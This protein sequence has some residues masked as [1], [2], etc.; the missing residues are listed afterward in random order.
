MLTLDPSLQ[1]GKALIGL[2]LSPVPPCPG[3]RMKPH[4]DPAAG[5]E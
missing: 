4:R 5:E 1:P 3:A 2:G